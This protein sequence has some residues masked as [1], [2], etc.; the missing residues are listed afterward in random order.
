MG[1]VR[2]RERERES[3]LSLPPPLFP[4]PPPPNYPQ[5]KL[6]AVQHSEAKKLLEGLEEKERKAPRRSL[7]DRGRP[8]NSNNAILPKE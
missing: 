8:N 4:P 5:N 7:K 6:L 1:R 3:H 2:E